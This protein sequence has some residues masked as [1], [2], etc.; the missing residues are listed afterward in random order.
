[1][2]R[3]II[4]C[5]SGTFGAVLPKCPKEVVVNGHRATNVRFEQGLLTVEILPDAGVHDFEIVLKL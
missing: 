3:Y 5:D 1:M 2:R 4:V